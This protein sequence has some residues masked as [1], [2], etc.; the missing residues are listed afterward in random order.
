MKILIVAAL[1]DAIFE[2][3]DIFKLPKT[4]NSIPSDAI[5]ELGIILILGAQSFFRQCDGQRRPRKY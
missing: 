3:R 2:H 4:I 1:A 5:Y